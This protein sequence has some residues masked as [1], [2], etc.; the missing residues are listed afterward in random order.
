MKNLKMRK[1]EKVKDDLKQSKIYPKTK[2]KQKGIF[3]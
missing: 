2:K 1:K 3:F